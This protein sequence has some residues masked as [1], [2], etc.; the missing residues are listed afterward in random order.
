M[1]SPDFK[2]HLLTLMSD[3]LKQKGFK[4]SGSNFAHSNGDLTY[5]VNLQSSR[6]STSSCLRVTIN[7]EIFSSFIYEIEDTSLPA[8]HSRHFSCRVGFYLEPPQDL[9]WEIADGDT[10][11]TAEGEISRM[12]T[13]YVLPEFAS[14]PTSQHLIDMWRQGKAPGLTEKKRLDY[15]RMISDTSLGLTDS[16]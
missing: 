7:I 13:D 9:W 16:G 15:L 2:K 3:M 5:Y 1:Q 14:I 10:L 6:S 8:R 4:R 12:L 11:S